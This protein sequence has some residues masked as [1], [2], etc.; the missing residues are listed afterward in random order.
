MLIIIQNRL[1]I[2][3]DKGNVLL[4]IICHQ[5]VLCDHP[6]EGSSEMNCKLL[7]ADVLTTSESSKNS[8]SLT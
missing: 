1:I 5:L 4:L 8:V 7:V 6:G 2:K 3:S